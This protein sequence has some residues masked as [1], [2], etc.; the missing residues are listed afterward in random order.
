MGRSSDILN[1]IGRFFKFGMET[2]QFPSSDKRYRTGSYWHLLISG[3]PSAVSI[4]IVSK[5]CC[6]QKVAPVRMC[7][8]YSLLQLPEVTS[9]HL[10]SCEADPFKLKLIT[11]FTKREIFAAL[12]RKKSGKL[13][14]ILIEQRQYNPLHYQTRRTNQDHL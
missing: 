14:T 12:I 13:K 6:H 7:Q 9:A 11:L 5:S 1:L 2:K 8:L 4:H 10:E 3:R